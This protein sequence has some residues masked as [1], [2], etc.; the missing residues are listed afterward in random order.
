MSIDCANSSRWITKLEYNRSYYSLWDATPQFVRPRQLGRLMHVSTGHGWLF[1]WPFL[2]LW[3]QL[4]VTTVKK[5]NK[6]AAGLVCPPPIA[7]SRS[8]ST[9]ITE[10]RF[11]TAHWKESRRASK[12]G[13]LAI[14]SF[15]VFLLTSRSATVYMRLPPGISY[16][17]ALI[18]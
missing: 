6:K 7:I 18:L 14:L 3:A 1:S 15:Q 4:C 5:G 10:Y 16:S 9:N 17:F 12:N 8:P 13:G 11:R 2:A